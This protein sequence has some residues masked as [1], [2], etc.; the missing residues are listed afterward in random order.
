[1][2]PNKMWRKLLANKWTINNIYV[3]GDWVIQIVHIISWAKNISG[4]YLSA[5]VFWNPF[6]D[7]KYTWD[8]IISRSLCP[9]YLFK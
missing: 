2:I 4:N 7:Y 8:N 6:R 1:M 9:K 5:K 3:G